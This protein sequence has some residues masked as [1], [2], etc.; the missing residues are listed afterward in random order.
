MGGGVIQLVATGI[1]DLCLIGDPQI[2]WF[3]V[4]Y[5]RYNEFSMVDYPIKINGDPQPG[6]THMIKI[7]PIADKLNRICLVADIPT[8]EVEAFLPTVDNVQ[9]IVD[10]FNI[11]LNFKPTKKGTDTVQYTDLF[12]DDPTSVGSQMT[13]LTKQLNNT[14][15]SRLDMLQYMKSTYSVS[16]NR[17]LGQ[18]IAFEASGINFQAFSQNVDVQGYCLLTPEKTRELRHSTTKIID[19]RE[20]SFMYYPA[21]D[22]NVTDTVNQA[23]SSD[24]KYSFR[25]FKGSRISGQSQFHDS[26]PQEL[27]KGSNHVSMSARDIILAQDLSTPIEL[28]IPPVAT[29]L[30]TIDKMVKV[31]P[32]FVPGYTKISKVTDLDAINDIDT[33]RYHI[34][35]SID[36]LR[37]VQQRNIF[38][39]RVYLNS[40][41]I[42]GAT[43]DT[44]DQILEQTKNTNLND[45]VQQS[46]IF[47]NFNYNEALMDNPYEM[48]IYLFEINDSVLDVDYSVAM[49]NVLDTGRLEIK[50]KYIDRA[51]QTQITIK[52]QSGA[53]TGKFNRYNINENALYDSTWEIK[54]H[55]LESNDLIDLDQ[56]TGNGFFMLD[57]TDYDENPDH[58]NVIDTDPSSQGISGETVIKLN[59][60]FIRCNADRL[61]FA[62]H[63]IK[64][65]WENSIV[66]NT[67]VKDPTDP[68]KT[69]PKQIK[70]DNL[71]NGVMMI[72]KLFKDLYT[73][74]GVINSTNLQT[75]LT[76]AGIDINS[77]YFL[78]SLLISMQ[79]DILNT[80]TQSRNYKIQNTPLY[81][82]VD[83]KNKIY[84]KLIKD[85][86]YIDQR[87]VGLNT[88]LSLSPFIRRQVTK[89][90]PLTN[91]VTIL[92]DSYNPLSAGGY[93]YDT[94]YPTDTP[95]PEAMVN[96]RN[97]VYEM[98]KYIMW[99]YYLENIYPKYDPVTDNKFAITSFL[100]LLS[101]MLINVSKNPVNIDPQDA[102][103]TGVDDLTT[104]NVRFASGDVNDVTRCY[105]YDDQSLI[106][107][108]E[109]LQK[110]ASEYNV[111]ST[112]DFKYIYASTRYG[113][114]TTPDDQTYPMFDG[115]RT[116]INREIEFFHV[117]SSFTHDNISQNET[118]YNYFVNLIDAAYTDPR[119]YQKTISYAIVQKYLKSYFNDTKVLDSTVAMSQIN[120][121][122][123]TLIVK[124]M[125]LTLINYIKIVFGMW[126]NSTYSD[127]NIDPQYLFNIILGGKVFSSQIDYNAN[128]V[129]NRMRQLAIDGLVT[130]DQINELGD[131]MLMRAKHFVG[132]NTIYRPFLGFSYEFKIDYTDPHTYETETQLII[133]SSNFIDKTDTF[134]QGSDFKDVFAT[135]I[136]VQVQKIKTD[137]EQIARNNPVMRNNMK[138][139]FWRDFNTYM[140]IIVN[141]LNTDLGI[142]DTETFHYYYNTMVLNHLPLAITY[143]YGEY[144]QYA[145]NTQF[146]SGAISNGINAVESIDYDM[147]PIEDEDETN[148]KRFDV[149][150]DPQTGFYVRF[151]GTDVRKDPKCPFH[152]HINQY[153]DA[154]SLDTK[155]A[156][157]L[158]S[159]DV[160]I[161]S[162]MCPIC[163]RT[164]EFKRLFETLLNRTLFGPSSQKI[165]DDTHIQSLR[166]NGYTETTGNVSL[167][168][169]SGQTIYPDYTTYIYRPEDVIYDDVSKSYFHI[170]TEFTLYRMAAIL[171]RYKHMIENILN[172]DETSFNEFITTITPSGSQIGTLNPLT[173]KNEVDRFNDFVQYLTDMRSNTDDQIAQFSTQ[174]NAVINIL[175]QT[176][177]DPDNF[178]KLKAIYDVHGDSDIVVG[179]A[180]NY[181]EAVSFIGDRADLNSS[182][183][184]FAVI[185]NIVYDKIDVTVSGTNI[186]RYQMYRGNIVLWVLMSH[187]IINSYNTFFNNVLDPRQINA[188]SSLNSATTNTD[189][190]LYTE[191]YTLL[192]SSI[193]SKFINQ[194][195]T[196]D[197]Y[198][199][200]QT[201]E[202]PHTVADSTG[203]VTNDLSSSVC[204]KAINYCRQLMI[205]Y[206]MLL[207][208]YKRMKF[209]LTSVQNTSLNSDAYYYNFSHLI[210]K[211][212]LTDTLSTIQNFKIIN[213]NPEKN[214]NINNSFYYPD[215]SDHY[216]VNPPTFR[217][218]RKNETNPTFVNDYQLFDRNNN[219]H[220][221]QGFTINKLMDMLRMLGIHD[222]KLSSYQDVPDTINRISSAQY[223]DAL[224]QGVKLIFNDN[225]KQYFTIDP[226]SSTLNNFEK[227]LYGDK[228]MFTQNVGFDFNYKIFRALNL[229]LLNRMWYYYPTISNILYDQYYTP[230]ILKS[231]VNN[232]SSA[233]YYDDMSVTSRTYTECLVTSP[234][235][236]LR[237]KLSNSI[238]NK[239]THTENLTMWEDIFHAYTSSGI[240]PTNLAAKPTVAQSR[241][242]ETTAY[243]NLFNTYQ[244]F[245][246]SYRLTDIVTLFTGLREQLEQDNGSITAFITRYNQIIDGIVDRVSVAFKINDQRFR[247]Q[248]MQMTLTLE[249]AKA[250][251]QLSNLVK[252]NIDYI[253]TSLNN[254]IN[255]KDQI[256]NNVPE[257]QN[258]TQIKNVVRASF[259]YVKNA[260]NNVM[261]TI[262]SLDMTD[263]INFVKQNI[264]QVQSPADLSAMLKRHHAGPNGLIALAATFAQQFD[265]QLNG[266]LN[267]VKF[268]FIDTDTDTRVYTPSVLFELRNLSILNNFRSYHDVLLLILA[269]IV[270]FISPNDIPVN[271]YLALTSGNSN[272]YN[273][274]G[275]TV[276]QNVMSNVFIASTILSSRDESYDQMIQN[277]KVS[278]DA[279]LSPMSKLTVLTRYVDIE[280]SKVDTYDRYDFNIVIPVSADTAV[281]L[282][283][284]TNESYYEHKQRLIKNRIATDPTARIAAVTRGIRSERNKMRRSM[285]K[286]PLTWESQRTLTTTTTNLVQT[287]VGSDLHTQIV[288]LL[289]GVVPKHAW[290][291]YLGFRL[292]EEVGL[293]IDGEQIDMQ[294][295]ELML[296]LHKM[297][298]DVEHERGDN[299]MLGHIPEMYTISSDPKPAMRLYI[300]FYLFFGKG[301]G[302]SLPLVNM[303][304]SDVKI[305]LKLRKF[306][307]LFY[308]EDGGTL[309]K[310]V[311]LK[312]HLLGNYIYLGADERRQCAKIKSE[313]LMERFVNSGT[314]V[315]DAKDLR[316]SMITDYGI[317]NNVLKIRYHFSDPCKYL[318][319]KIN[320]EYPDAQPSD[321]VSWDLNDYRVRY[322]PTPDASD[323]VYTNH[324]GVIDVKSKIIN[325]VNRTLIEFNGKT[326]EQWKDPTYFQTLQPYYKCMNALDSGESFYGLCLF[327]KPLQPSGATNFSQ[328][329]DL[330][331][332]FEINKQIVDLM[333]TTGL[334][335]RINMWECCYNVFVA[336]SGF[337]A[338]RFYGV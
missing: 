314:L 189:P 135:Q 61:G 190:D 248:Q 145:M 154:K 94:P 288:K 1:P 323:P 126:K 45:I 150:P 173:G 228:I 50:A 304:Y 193:D 293:I 110:A 119:N 27:E 87:K 199:S 262:L 128:Y 133:N 335:I 118:V 263:D 221:R 112:F 161:V 5:R 37:R 44:V 312:F 100:Q 23:R 177:A 101:Y 144:L 105:V 192:H 46:A 333:K 194:N 117:I 170:I 229:G 121:D 328:I 244:Y 136:D 264:D 171:F 71:L 313:A 7:G 123:S 270:S 261:S 164:F 96:N 179:E 3:K 147:I 157:Y 315:R 160:S 311:K 321:I 40:L 282:I 86:I 142:P 307:D 330:S 241:I 184:S 95:S 256:L 25:S 84:N 242:N 334:K 80:Q 178:D 273:L 134:I 303:M 114:E 111:S 308:M 153:P 13:D 138:Y 283:Q 26:R 125:N 109:T 162:D 294:D 124:A 131:P 233:D 284:N 195:G 155:S 42:G 31:Y 60:R 163:F 66:K 202:Y 167:N 52:G 201:R 310:P 159:N 6:D 246:G 281:D 63:T 222:E 79:D 320:V 240:D 324:N 78:H 305:K 14:Y 139:V 188:N 291:R 72:T 213:I 224:S 235:I 77:L 255:I 81:N 298:S 226:I 130:N 122:I 247:T 253:N 90:D 204:T 249:N 132:A 338:L 286:V 206:N 181:T 218:V 53:D 2:T 15:E 269:K 51:A 102:S 187:N 82:S 197:Y 332:Y 166:P 285:L 64:R 43:T 267:L 89:Q 227:Y 107:N 289:T 47:N 207:S 8:P 48:G 175:T 182:L 9:S 196:I 296:L 272:F 257:L 57:V 183:E 59:P 327:P 225:F 237:D 88:E 106:E 250:V 205:F 28:G 232:S 10:K 271:T 140:R 69:I 55:V 219:Y 34:M 336:I 234:L 68:T 39:R 33:K 212:Y 29:R 329:E 278:V 325:I 198:R 231:Q 20:D 115:V 317:A 259:E 127:T 186:L 191:I 74:P 203:A 83:I 18:Y 75:L 180:E 275:V 38:L 295:G 300:Q 58:Q 67:M 245:L 98:T 62:P 215:T 216:F 176:N 287:Y 30:P 301:Y 326:R 143:Y 56:E 274:S 152:G 113:E 258:Q 230:V 158:R 120:D 214:P 91:I 306:E 41:G 266:I 65:V 276:N 174:M 211:A 32:N 36:F 146:L 290:A 35:I 156:Q 243:T 331:F 172:M 12:S 260:L 252:E 209:L 280:R 4:V 236:F 200:K 251:N 316:V 297:T 73:I 322:I 148:A 208:R 299:L 319:W 223:H 24:E 137:M 16:K 279:I 92:S 93:I 254:L 168:L 169:N 217:D 49:L 239:H 238:V 302:N 11:T 165:V 129:L 116:C 277:I 108:F 318:L 210:T 22:S 104:Q 265:D 70:P 149:E 141:N 337:G 19:L 220:L 85:I 76:G 292:I 54:D 268:I 103:A 185:P 151:L 21:T 17:Y 309:K 99:T 97:I